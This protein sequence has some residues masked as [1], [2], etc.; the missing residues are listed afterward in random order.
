MAK[1]DPTELRTS[2]PMR[3]RAQR[4]GRAGA[5]A[6]HRRLAHL[7]LTIASALV[8]VTGQSCSQSGKPSAGITLTLI[9]QSWV[10]KQSQALLNEEL[11]QFTR[12]TGMRVEVLPARRIRYRCD[13]AGSSREQSPRPKVLH[14]GARDRGTLS[15]ADREQYRERQ[16][17]CPAIYDRRRTAVLQ[18]RSA[19]SIRVPRPAGDLGRT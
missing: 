9:D 15:R 19:A 3:T 4:P 7:L 17:R 5:V 8:L 18:S 16:T 1:K 14:P 6:A 13:L 11:Q 10:D 2:V 12:Q